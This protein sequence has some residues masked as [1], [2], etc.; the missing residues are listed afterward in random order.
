MEKKVFTGFDYYSITDNSND[1]F[2]SFGSQL[3]VGSVMH[4]RR[5]RKNVLFY[6]II[7]GL[8]YKAG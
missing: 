1:K 6:N 5:I 4:R 8:K 7:S 3:N 2:V